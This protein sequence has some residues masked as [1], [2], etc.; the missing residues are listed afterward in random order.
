[1]V[2]MNA[3]LLWIRVYPADGEGFMASCQHRWSD[4]V[5]KVWRLHKYI[6]KNITRVT[7]L[8]CDA[9]LM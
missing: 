2:S 6:S 9:G 1:M 8:T 7:R 4:R 3:Y 5:W